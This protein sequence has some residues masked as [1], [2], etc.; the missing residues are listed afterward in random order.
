MK[1]ILIQPFCFSKL[2]KGPT[3]SLGTCYIGSSMKSLCRQVAVYDF[4][5][6][7]KPEKYLWSK[8][9]NNL[10]DTKY[11]GISITAIPVYVSYLNLLKVLKYIK[12]IYSKIIIFIG[13]IAIADKISILE[14]YDFIDYIF[15]GES[16]NIVPNVLQST[17]QQKIH[18][19]ENIVDFNKL[20]FPI[21]PNNISNS[22]SIQ[23][24]RGCINNCSFCS[25][26]KRNWVPRSEYSID[27]EIE[28]YINL[29]KD[30]A[31][32]IYFVDEN[33]VGSDGE[34]INNIAK[35]I[36]NKYSSVEWAMSFSSNSDILNLDLEFLKRSKLNN[37]FI[38]IESINLCALKRYNKAFNLNKS[39]EI[40]KKFRNVNIN[41][42]IGYIPFDYWTSIDEVIESV[43]F[44]IEFELFDFLHYFYEQLVPFSTTQLGSKFI[45]EVLDNDF[46]LY[47]ALVENDYKYYQQNLEVELARRIFTDLINIGKKYYLKYNNKID[48]VSITRIILDEYISILSMFKKQNAGKLINKQFFNLINNLKH[49]VIP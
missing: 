18:Y 24:S 40:I 21:L 31:K 1:A 34:R 14:K 49:M 5:L 7:D 47:E 17:S 41:V 9:I 25:I 28:R 11:L 38:G 37:V 4:N 29:V 13:G 20:D 35:I 10:E 8:I 45:D 33:M 30:E 36:Y 15:V 43:K 12:E 2:S 16:D 48:S 23:S 19:S 46:L 22:I 39:M 32:I 42:S 27:S 44:I 26:S 3:Y 6:Y